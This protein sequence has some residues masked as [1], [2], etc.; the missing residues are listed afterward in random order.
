[1]SN[2]VTLTGASGYIAR[3]ILV[4]LLDGGYRVRATLRDAGKGDA[5]F[6]DI[7][8]Y[9]ASPEDAR[10]GLEFATL[11]LES[12]DGWDVALAGSDALV[13]TASPFPIDM[14]D[15][16]MDLIRPAVEGT[17][18][19]LGAAT[20]AGVRRVILT[21][22]VA[23]IMGDGTKAGSGPINEDDWTDPEED[24]ISAYSKSKT[25]AE[26]AAWDHVKT[27]DPA[28]ELTT[29]CPSLVM[30]AP[31]GASNG[32]SMSIVRRMLRRKDPMLANFG[33]SIVD[34]GDVAEAHVRALS[35]PD[36]IG[37]RIM[38]AHD[39]MWLREIAE[40]LKARFPERKFVTRVAPDWIV[41]IL[42][43]F[44]G[45]IRLI[46]PM[47]GQEM[48]TDASRAR[49]MLGIE[50]RDPRDSLEDAARAL[51]KMGLD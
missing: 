39:F 3:H 29:I 15:N 4:R 50:F 36:S 49:G 47:L 43:R 13:H 21:S 20:K 6:D 44:D 37:K 14:P 23:S 25:L 32:S 51:I 46:V 42:A 10:T 40:T 27:V 19:A 28:M 11:D 30:G 8:P 1:M 16:E 2:L 34:V 45:T 41:R 31:L 18:R 5:L 26:M 9:L 12:D 22:S 7:A 35:T 24:K 33:L 48:R 17:K 38:M